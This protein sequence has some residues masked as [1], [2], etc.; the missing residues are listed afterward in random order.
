MRILNQDTDK[1]VKNLLI[2]LTREEAME[3]K[4]DLEQLI[5]K[6][7]DQDHAHLNDADFQREITV[8]IY[9]SEK[10]WFFNDRV[11]QLIAED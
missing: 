6:G 4:D 1:S 5:S 11:K 3:L 8:A 10:C 9:N 7:Q 2:L